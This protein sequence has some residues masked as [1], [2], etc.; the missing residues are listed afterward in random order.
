MTKCAL[1]RVIHRE[2]GRDYVGI[3]VDYKRR[4]RVHK[5][6]AARGDK[7]HFYSALRKYGPCSFDWKVIAWTSCFKGGCQL[8]KLARHLGL[9]HYNMTLG[10]EGTLG[11]PVN[12]GRKQTDE[13]RAKLRACR[14]GVA[15]PAEEVLRRAATNSRRYQQLIKQRAT[16]LHR[17]LL[18][19]PYTRPELAALVGVSRSC[20]IRTLN[21]YPNVPC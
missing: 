1:Y 8:E 15:R 9:G 7:S 2:T 6:R 4:W 11:C 5:Q 18:Q 3:S 10:G 14:A 19:H 16:A 12:L 13:T 20:I 21:K 17:L